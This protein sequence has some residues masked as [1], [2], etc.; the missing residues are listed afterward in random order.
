MVADDVAPLG[1]VPLFGDLDRADLAALSSRLRR[2]RYARGEAVFLK[3]DPGT[4]LCII[5][6]G[7]VKLGL[8]LSKGAR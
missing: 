6:T 7:R 8:R 4:S 3:G 1:R 2:R 5:E